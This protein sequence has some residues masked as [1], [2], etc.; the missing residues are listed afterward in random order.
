MVPVE[1]GPQ[2][3]EWG[4]LI[5][6]GAIDGLVLLNLKHPT[7]SPSNLPMHLTPHTALLHL[8]LLVKT[9]GVGKV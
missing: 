5:C 8:R 4:A 3:Q 7:P 1:A 6:L 9:N 2:D